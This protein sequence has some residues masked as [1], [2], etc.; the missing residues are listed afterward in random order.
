MKFYNTI[1]SVFST[2]IIEKFIRQINS[3]IISRSLGPGGV[4]LYTLFF[5][6]AKNLYTFSEFGMGASGIYFIRRKLS[7]EKKIIENA[8]VFSLFIGLILSLLVF[9]FRKQLG[10]FLLDEQEYYIFL[11]SLVIPMIMLASIFSILLRGLKKFKIFNLF[12]VIKPLCLLIF[13]FIGLIIYQGDLIIAI[14]GQIVAIILSGFWIMYKMYKIIPF[15]LRFHQETFI[16]NIG[17]GLKQHFLKIIMMFLSTTSIYILKGLTTKEVVGQYGIVL[18]ILGLISFIKMSISLVLTPKASELNDEKMH[19]FI[20]KV[21]R[22]TF[23][24]TLFAVFLIAIIGPMYVD[25][26]YGDKFKYA[27][28]AFKWFLPG[29]VFNSVCV[30]LHRDFTARENPVQYKPIIA[31]LVGAIVSVVGSYYLILNFSS[32]P[33]EALGVSYNFSYFIALILLTLMFMYD[34]SIKMNKIF[35]INNN[36]IVYYKKILIELYNKPRKSNFDKK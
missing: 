21:S 31:Y 8:V 33:L 24:I 36:D 10:S 35:I 4:G 1:I 22:N 5:S 16:N 13:I 14:I 34:S 6:L 28:K 12:T 32:T 20:A 27:A 30:M 19:L 2:R 7:K 18:S 26:L 17:Y 29:I 15:K 25:I 9:I 23:S 3:V 11:L